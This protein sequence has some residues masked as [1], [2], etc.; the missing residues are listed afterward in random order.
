MASNGVIH[1]IDKVLI[2]PA[3]SS[4]KPAEPRRRGYRRPGAPRT[5]RE[6]S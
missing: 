5:I 1:V 6:R 2:P 3:V 4:R